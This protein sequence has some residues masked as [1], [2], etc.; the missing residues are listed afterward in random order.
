M[1][2]IQGKQERREEKRRESAA[3]GVGEKTRSCQWGEI[4]ELRRFAAFFLVWPEGE[5]A[6]PGREGESEASAPS[7]S[8]KI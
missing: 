3:I 5:G 8:R 6:R 7:D 2:Y 1:I 4:I